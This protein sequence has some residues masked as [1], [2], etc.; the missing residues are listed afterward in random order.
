MTLSVLKSRVSLVVCT[1]SLAL[2]GTAVSASAQSIGV[3]KGR[4]VEEASDRGVPDAQVRVTGTE[5]VAVT[6]SNGDY[7]I[8]AAPAGTREVSVRRIGYARQVRGVTVAVNQTVTA[9][10][11]INQAAST[12]DAVVVN[13]TGG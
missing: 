8:A 6:N 13:G 2:A 3:I 4:V 10:F 9:N 11:A 7:T 5:L 12:L 1:V